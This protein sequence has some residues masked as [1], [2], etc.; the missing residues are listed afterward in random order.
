[1][2]I[3]IVLESNGDVPEAD[4]DP[5]AAAVERQLHVHVPVAFP[6]GSDALARLEG[7]TV[8]CAHRVTLRTSDWI[9]YVDRGWR[10]YHPGRPDTVGFHSVCP[11]RDGVI[12]FAAVNP[13]NGRL[14]TAISHEAME[15]LGRPLLAEYVTLP[16]GSRWAFEVADPCAR[17]EY[18]LDGVWVS[19]FTTARYWNLPGDDRRYDHMGLISGPFELRPGGYT[20]VLAH[21]ITRPDGT[22]CAFDDQLYRDNGSGGLMPLTL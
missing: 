7:L 22:S 17:D 19:N 21:S 12:P 13:E 16:N 15:M 5:I 11:T 14:S 4:L 1:M 2:A 6:T 10:R 20:K 8:V 3:R 9:C 18:E